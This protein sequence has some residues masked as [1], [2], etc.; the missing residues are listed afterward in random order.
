MYLTGIADEASQNI[1]EQIKVTK[2]LGWNAIESRFI[3]SKNIHDITDGEFDEVVTALDGSGVYINAFGSAIGNWGKDVRDDFLITEQEINR[4]IP[5][6]K[7]LGAKFVRVMSYKVLEGEEQ[8]VEERIRR[9]RL[10]VE[11][12]AAE[13]ITAVHENCMNYGGMSWQHTLELTDAIPGMKLVFDTANPAFN[14]DRSKVGGPW[15][16]PLEFYHKV[17]QHIAYVHVKDCLNPSADNN[18]QELYVYPGDGDGRVLEI[19]T[20]LKNSGYTGGISIEPHL[21]A[22]FHSTDSINKTDEDPK[23]IYVRYGRRLMEML[24][25]IGYSY[26]PYLP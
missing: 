5:R 16:D 25:S 18:N 11:A 10:I 26:E 9:L 15:Q 3:N 13:G 17:K 22:V 6:M 23:E 19:M 20:D 12:F 14:R 1:F 4:A 7:K 2:E 8:F 21:A 24:D